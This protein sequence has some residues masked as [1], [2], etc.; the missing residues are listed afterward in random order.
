MIQHV[1]DFVYVSRVE[2]CQR[3]SGFLNPYSL[4]IFDDHMLHNQFMFI[5]K[6]CFLVKSINCENNHVPLD[7]EN[8]KFLP[9][10]CMNHSWFMWNMSF[11]EI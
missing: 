2:V 1:T 9:R 6:T 3:T 7:I 11:C 5:I 10:S 4:L 8:A